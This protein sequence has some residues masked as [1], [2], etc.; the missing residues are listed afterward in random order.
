MTPPTPIG[1]PADGPRDP[2]SREIARLWTAAQPTVSAFVSGIVADFRDRDDI[3][4]DVAVAVLDSFDHYDPSRPFLP[5]VLGVARNRTL[6]HQR[7]RGRD[8]HVFDSGAM[9]AVAQAAAEVRG[10]E[11]AASQYLSDCLAALDDRTRQLCVQRYARGLTPA[12]IAAAVG[13]S[14][15]GVAKALQ[16]ARERLRSCIERKAAMN[17]R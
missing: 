15:N 6:A 1:R 5:W 8:R 14:A 10:D 16:R 17:R 3:L 9:E 2:R 11:L 4:Q 12:A 13:G 7:R